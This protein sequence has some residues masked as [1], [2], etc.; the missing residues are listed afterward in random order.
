MG[1]EA[2]RKFVRYATTTREFSIR[3]GRITTLI[4]TGELFGNLRVPGFD[5]AVDRM[6]ICGSM[7]LNLDMKKILE[8]RGFS[9]G[10]NSK[11]GEYV[12]ERAFVD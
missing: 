2:T 3:M 6:M 10:A 7:G 4:D 12:V 8:G 1:E 5:P 11:P 9:E